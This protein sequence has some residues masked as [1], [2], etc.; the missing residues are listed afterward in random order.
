[1]K[2]ISLPIRYGFVTGIVLIAYFLLL[3]LFGKSTN[4]VYSF[5][6]AAIT[7]FGIYEVIYISKIK[8]PATFTYVEGFKN[9]IITGFVATVAFT[10]FFLV[11][12]TEVNDMF[13]DQLLQTVKRNFDIDVGIVTF[14]VAIMGFA[15]TVVSALTVMQLFKNSN[16]MLSK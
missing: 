7:A 3:D 2:N 13:V 9:G 5:F 1:M 15:T 11:Y 10:I 16:N 12:A 8:S 4:P 14:I 6:N